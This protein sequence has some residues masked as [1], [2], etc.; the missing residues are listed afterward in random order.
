MTSYFIQ[1]NLQV[2][3]GKYDKLPPTS[4]NGVKNMVMN[5]YITKKKE[6]ICYF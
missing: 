1:T 3:K 4:S 6:L 5:Y 2:Q